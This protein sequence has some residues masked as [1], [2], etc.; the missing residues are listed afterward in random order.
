MLKRI[1]IIV[2]FFSFF[3]LLAQNNSQDSIKSYLLN[4]VVITATKTETPVIE[5]GNSVTVITSKQIEE[6]KKQDVIELLNTVPGITIVQSGGPG[7]LASIFFRG[8]NSNHTLVLIDG[9]TV[10]DPASTDNAFDFSNLFIDDIEKIEVIRGPQSTLYGSDAIAGVINIITKKGTKENNFSVST[11]G[12]TYNTWKGNIFASGTLENLNYYADAGRYT[13]DGFSAADKNLG[14]TEKDGYQNNNCELRLGYKFTNY[15][16]LDFIS[17]YLKDKVYLDQPGFDDDFYSS[18]SEETVLKLQANLNLFDGFW[19]NTFSV[20]H[21]RD[22]R[23]YSNEYVSYLNSNYD[24]YNDKFEWQNNFKLDEQNTVIAGFEVAQDK[25]VVNEALSEDKV[26]NKG[27]Y[28]QEQS[29][30]FNSLFTTIGVRYDY[31][32]KFGS[33]VTYKFS[34]AYIIRET[35]TKLRASVG[36]GFKAPSLY[37][38]YAQY[39][40]NANLKPEKSTGFDAGV[41]QYLLNDKLTVSLS[42]FYNSFK[43]L[44]GYDTVTYQ[45]INIEKAESKGVETSIKFNAPYNIEMNLNYTYTNTKD[46]SDN[47]TDNG[48]ALLRRPKNKLSFNTNIPVIENLN[49]FVEVIYTGKY[50]DISY[51]TYDRITMPD[52]TLFNAAV[53]EQLLKNLDLYIRFENIFNKQYEQVSGYGTAGFSIYVGFKFK[54]L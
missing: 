47:T 7:Q 26:T 51:L 9:I 33:E 54:F 37:D 30:F 8:A 35:G 16:S 17:K 13:T 28:L 34:P 52:Y 6:S 29:K 43:D 44:I 49:V 18:S 22:Y 10:N 11:E 24:G 40:G 20:S 32:E 23:I 38:L 2:F 39:Y 1:F 12:G 41:D 14:N 53:T 48:K 46:L 21:Y 50:D 4:E 31:N 27:V 42:Y 25:A 15:L 45:S 3:K 5:L 19:D 36:T